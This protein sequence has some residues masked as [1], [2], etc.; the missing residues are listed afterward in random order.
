[1]VNRYNNFA[2]NGNVKDTRKKLI[3]FDC[4]G[5]LYVPA[6]IH[7]FFQD[8]SFVLTVEDG[9]LVF[10]PVEV[11]SLSACKHYPFL[12]SKLI[13]NFMTSESLELEYLGR[14]KIVKHGPSY[15]VWVPKEWKSS[16]FADVFMADEDT[17]VVRRVTKEI[18]QEVFK[19]CN[20]PPAPKH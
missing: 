9:R 20:L 3:K 2:E 11:D 16:I 12:K 1:M 13:S 17:L 7:R 8:C 6:F 4:C 5:K 15:Y 10:T 14:R 19:K 18:E